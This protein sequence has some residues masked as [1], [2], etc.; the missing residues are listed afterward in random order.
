MTTV[1]LRRLNRATLARQSLLD[2]RSASVD[3][4]VSQI[5]AV[6]AQEPGSPYVALWNRIAG[7]DPA[8]LDRAFAHRTV[9]KATLMRITLH[10]VASDDYP[11]FQTG[12]QGTLRAS[13]LN[14][15]RFRSLGLSVEQADGVVP[16][17]LEFLSDPRDN[18]EVRAW[19]EERFGERPDPGPWWALRS[20]AP[21]V[22]APTGPPWSFGRRP[23]YTAAPTPP[24]RDGDAAVAYLIRRYLAGFGP[25]SARDVAQFALLRQSTIRPALDV[26]SEELV[27]LEGPDGT[28]LF[29]LPGGVVPDEDTPAP[30]RLMAMWDSVL[31]AYAD[32]S[33]VIPDEHR[34]HV[35][36]RNG[37]VLPTLLVDGWVAGVWRPT[38]GGIEAMAFDALDDEAWDALAVEAR[39]LMP[40]I[41]S[42]DPELYRRYDGWWEKLPEGSRVVLGG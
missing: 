34:A 15:R 23:S 27:S 17:L 8:D 10:A 32:R 39:S 18:G 31:L 19:L 20:Y 41:A 33:R 13:R 40:L 21:V 42:R 5:V 24:V 25:A 36:R 16:E 38:G 2:R 22:H 35:I 4:T 30:P 11:W 37:D 1:T 12:M 7:F 26:L 9:V 28:T 3:E 6:Q 14:D 29:D